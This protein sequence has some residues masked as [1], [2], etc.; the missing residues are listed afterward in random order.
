MGPVITLASCL[1]AAPRLH[2]TEENFSRSQHVSELRKQI[3]VWRDRSPPLRKE[4]QEKDPITK[5]ALE[6]GPGLCSSLF[7]GA[8]QHMQ[9]LRL[10]EATKT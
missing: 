7:R 3:R 1:E 10:Q 5:R 9:R 8:E 2:S 6:I 4:D